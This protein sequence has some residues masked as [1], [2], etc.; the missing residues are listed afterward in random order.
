AGAD[1]IPGVTQVDPVLGQRR[2]AAR[3]NRLVGWLAD[4]D[5][6]PSPTIPLVART[7]NAVT[8]GQAL[9][10]AGAASGAPPADEVRRE[11]RRLELEALKAELAE[12]AAEA[13]LAA[14]DAGDQPAESRSGRVASDAVSGSTSEPSSERPSPEM[15]LPEPPSEEPRVDP[16]SDAE[17]T[18]AG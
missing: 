5:T 7:S 18:A 13:R 1:E 15:P 11:I 10:G 4:V 8:A 6:E 9:E 2:P 3:P 14:L 17:G 16:S 12:R